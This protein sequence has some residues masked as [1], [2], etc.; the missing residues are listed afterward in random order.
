LFETHYLA[1]R[2]NT[3]NN[4]VAKH[5]STKRSGS[6]NGRFGKSQ[7]EKKDHKDQIIKERAGRIIRRE[8]RRK[9]RERQER[10][11]QKKE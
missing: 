2:K 4:C 1:C 10:K 7:N 6:K 5:D 11:K 8:I 9:T 3:R